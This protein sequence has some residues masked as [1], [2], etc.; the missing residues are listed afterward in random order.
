M[1]G[2]RGILIKCS[3]TKAKECHKFIYEVTEVTKC[4]NPDPANP[5]TCRNG[6]YFKKYTKVLEAS[7]PLGGICVSCCAEQKNES[8][9]SDPLGGF[10]GDVER[11]QELANFFRSPLN[12]HAY[13]GKYGK[14]NAHDLSAASLARSTG[15]EIATLHGGAEGLH[16]EAE[17]VVVDLPSEDDDYDIVDAAEAREG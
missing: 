11:D 8:N 16:Q 6:Q 13:T 12:T 10:T 9:G 7:A 14:V 3:G 4:A 2:Y 1:C 15:W 17:F 5:E